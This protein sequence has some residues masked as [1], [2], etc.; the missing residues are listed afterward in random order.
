MSPIPKRPVEQGGNIGAT[1]QQA[2]STKLRARRHA[3]REGRL[4]RQPASA[5]AHPLLA[6]AEQ[7][8]ARPEQRGRANRLPRTHRVRRPR[9]HHPCR[10]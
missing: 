5:P 4:R 7:A 8:G 10:Q 9:R 2:I 3:G 6:A 1:S